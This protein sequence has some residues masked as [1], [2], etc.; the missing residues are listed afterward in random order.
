MNRK[1]MLDFILDARLEDVGKLSDYDLK[2]FTQKID[3]SKTFESVMQ[4]AENLILPIGTKN[5]LSDMIFKLEGSISDEFEYFNIKYYKQ[6]FSDAVNLI[7][8]A[9]EYKK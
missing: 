4:Y 8:D 3:E 6:G 5:K 7:F 9:K 2:F 1:N